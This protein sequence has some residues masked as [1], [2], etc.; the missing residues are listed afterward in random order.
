VTTLA[1]IVVLALALLILALPRVV[2]ARQRR[3]RL[4]D[5]RRGPGNTDAL[6]LAEGAW[7]ELLATARDHGV[8]LPVRRSVRDVATVLRRRALPGAPA[9]DQLDELVGFVERARYGLPFPVDPSTRQAVV[10]AVEAWTAVLAASVPART[11]RLAQV[12][13][14]SVLDRRGPGPVPDRQ[15]ELAGSR[16]VR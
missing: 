15:L 11:A 16:E 6:V 7:A 8:S 14:R 3:R 5:H 9:L 10:E 4:D 1:W 2:R 13:P 12:F